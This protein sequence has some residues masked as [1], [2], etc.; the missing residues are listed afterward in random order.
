MLSFFLMNLCYSS[1]WWTYAV[2]VWLFLQMKKGAK[3]G[4]S[5]AVFQ[6]R[7][8]YVCMCVCM[9]VS[10]YLCIY[11]SMYLYIYIS[12]YLCIYVC[13]PA[14]TGLVLKSYIFLVY[15]CQNIRTYMHTCTGYI[16]MFRR[17]VSVCRSK[18]CGLS[19]LQVTVVCTHTYI[20]THIH[21]YIHR[22]TDLCCIL[23]LPPIVYIRTCIH[24]YIHTYVYTYIRIY[25]HTYMHTYMYTD[26]CWRI[27][28]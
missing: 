14:L 11:V 5:A 9:Y 18:A 17:P 6:S 28:I 26:V 22:N 27:I 19:F 16:S 4:N 24:T 13:M 25:I 20:P 3:V 15:I 23:R 2:T 8:K 12:M 21:T 10:M 1:S 7:R